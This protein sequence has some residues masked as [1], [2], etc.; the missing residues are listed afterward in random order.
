MTLTA[1]LIAVVEDDTRLSEHLCALLQHLGWRTRAYTRANAFFAASR[2][3]IF[4]AIVLDLHLPD[5]H[6]VELIQKLSPEVRNK[7]IALTGRMDDSIVE[8][9]FDAGL[10]D[11]LLKPC[12]LLE[13]KCRLSRIFRREYTHTSK[14]SSDIPQELAHA[15]LTEKERQCALTLFAHC[16]QIVSRAQLL[17]AV[18]HLDERI[19]SRRVDTYVSRIRQKLG[20]HGEGPYRLVSVY[21]QGY[22]LEANP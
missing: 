2:S 22:R 5:V 18:W 16:N 7:T 13:L 1:P 14:Q 6:T 8:A 20:L 15:Q 12:R 10:A 4:D 9:S 19:T 21:G 17:W 3:I 11:F